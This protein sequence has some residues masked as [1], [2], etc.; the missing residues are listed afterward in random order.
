LAA[1]WGEDT[2]D[3]DEVEVRFRRLV[4]GFDSSV[5]LMTPASGRRGRRSPV[6]LAAPG[7]PPWA[8]T[9]AARSPVVVLLRLAA[10]AGA[11]AA[12]VAGLMASRLW[13]SSLGFW[14]LWL[15]FVLPGAVLVSVMAAESVMAPGGRKPIR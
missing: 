14:A 15:A 1:S 9:R 13:G 10:L 6:S 2:V 3:D 7:T 5:A 11:V 4:S 8:R 12:A